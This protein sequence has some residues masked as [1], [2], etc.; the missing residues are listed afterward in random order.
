MA[1]FRLW[2]GRITLLLHSRLHYDIL[3]FFVLSRLGLVNQRIF[4]EQWPSDTFNNS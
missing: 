3:C 4:A 2:T 1:T